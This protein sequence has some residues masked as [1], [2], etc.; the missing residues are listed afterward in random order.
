MGTAHCLLEHL[1]GYHFE[2]FFE[3]SR[4]EILGGNRRFAATLNYCYKL[5]Q[6]EEAQN[7][8]VFD[9]FLAS[10]HLRQWK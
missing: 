4:Q 5:G 2:E 1:L 10:L 3:R 7:A 9:D 8:C 6:A